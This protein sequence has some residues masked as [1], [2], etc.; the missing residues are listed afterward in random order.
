MMRKQVV[1]NW[2]MNG[3]AAVIGEVLDQLSVE[4]F[5]A[6]VSV[7]VPMPYLSAA[8][9]RLAASPIRV[10]AQNVS[11]Y[12]DGAYT[13]EVSARMLKDVGCSLAI[14]GH[15]ERRRYFAE[16]DAAVITKLARLLEVGLF[17]VFCVGETLAERDS[18][19]AEARIESQLA[20]LHTLMARGAGPERFCVAYE[21]VWAIGTGRAASNE[22]IS[23]MHEFIKRC[24]G[25]A[26]AV[27]YG[28]SV[29]ASNAADIMALTAV[30]GVLVGGAS[31]DAREF[32]AICRAAG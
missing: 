27:L 15:S 17:G 31:L 25:P 30:D 21:P 1:G 32:G 11:E 14:V 3:S 8:V 19:G 4:R 18:G 13:G 26:Y 20:Q 29:K 6:D 9:G 2:K 24:L 22:Q 5:S 23:S 10:G 7:C 28:G 16:T 12:G